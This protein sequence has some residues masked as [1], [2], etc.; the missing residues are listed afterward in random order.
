MLLP[1]AVLGLVVA[2]SVAVAVRLGAAAGAAFATV[3]ALTLGVLVLVVEPG[4]YEAFTASTTAAFAVTPF[5]CAVLA[6]LFARP[7]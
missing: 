4:S 6:A 2:A 3:G 5:P 1:Q 7:D